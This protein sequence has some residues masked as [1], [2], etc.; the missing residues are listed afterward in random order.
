MK[1]QQLNFNIWRFIKIT[2]VAALFTGAAILFF[3][4]ENDIEKIRAF[5]SPE[6]LPL[7]ESIDFS[8]QLKDSGIVSFTLKAPK[9]LRYES[10]GKQYTEFPEGMDLK[11]YDKDGNITSSIR[12]DY[13][14][15]SVIDN[16]WEAN[17]NVI[18]TNVKGDTLKTEHLI[19]EREKG[20][21][22]NNEYVKIISD[23]RIIWGEGFTSDEEMNDWKILKFRG[24]IY[25]TVDSDQN[26]NN[27]QMPENSLET[28]KEKTF[29][30]E[31]QLKK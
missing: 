4:C 8:T 13:A 15:Q 12:S 30:K 14:K 10:D 26:I 24:S 23:D 25:I 1:Q 20:I 21:I 6:N 9:V 5:S 11:K 19:W 7:V 29:G 22:Y 18:A 2:G 16:V 3:A 31:L 17:N 27:E 28:D